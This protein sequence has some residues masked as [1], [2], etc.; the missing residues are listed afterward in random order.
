MV[1]TGQ[2]FHMAMQTKGAFKALREGI[3]NGTIP[4]HMADDIADI[5]FDS[6]RGQVEEARKE[7]RHLEGVL[8]RLDTNLKAAKTPRAGHIW[9]PN[10]TVMNGLVNDLKAFHGWVVSIYETD[11]T[12]LDM[13]DPAAAQQVNKTISAGMGL[14]L[15]A[16]KLQAVR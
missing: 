6:L 14:T 15:I 9:K 7:V 11:M 13:I 12:I 1:M 2:A 8:G 3:N 10:E 16:R 4:P 5:I